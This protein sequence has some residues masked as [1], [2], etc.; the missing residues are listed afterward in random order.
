ML[1]TCLRLCL[2]YLHFHS[3]DDMFTAIII[4]IMKIDLPNYN[5]QTVILGGDCENGCIALA[6][7]PCL[8]LSFLTLKYLGPCDADMKSSS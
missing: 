3:H 4:R 8:S 7:G 1:M 5:L 2:I 6:N